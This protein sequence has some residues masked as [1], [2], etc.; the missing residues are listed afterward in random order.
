MTE[1]VLLD[2]W[3]W[4]EILEETPVG[5]AL[6]ERYLVPRRIRV[7][8]VDYTLAEIAAKLARI[9]RAEDVERALDAIASVEILPITVDVATLAARLQVEL[10]QENGHASVGDAVILAAARLL[11]ATLIS[12]D[13]CYAGQPDV[14]AS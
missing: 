3:A 10:R 5:I 9:N 7:L 14:R 12:G 8:S 6:A 11:G 1:A 4:W 2:S 13:P